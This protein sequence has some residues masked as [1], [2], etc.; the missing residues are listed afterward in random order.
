MDP[1]R[2]DFA[3]PMLAVFKAIE[4]VGAFAYNCLL[5][6]VELSPPNFRAPVAGERIASL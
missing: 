6:F 2:L 5:T 1:A 4:D 3:P